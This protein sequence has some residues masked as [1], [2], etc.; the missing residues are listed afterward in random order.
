MLKYKKIRSGDLM[1]I[2]INNQKVEVIITKKKG[3]KN[4]YLRVKE[5][6]KLYVTTS[7]LM[8]D[9]K[10]KNIIEENMESII[11]MYE[12]QSYKQ[13]LKKDFYYLG[14]K[15]DLIKTNGT[16]VVIGEEKIFIPMNFDQDKWLKK[17][18]VQLFK[19]RLDYWYD[20]FD[21]KIP[22]PSLT[23]RKMTSRWGVCNSKL[24]RVTLNLELI[25]KDISCLDYVIVH[26]LSHFVEMN[27]SDR[28][29][30]VVG[31]NYPNYKEI[32]RIMKNY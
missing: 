21:R 20:R 24:K 31:L 14:K 27:H 10:I 32:R 22:Y 29:W 9:R 26:E 17:E 16:N 4:T 15:Y 3:N 18:A 11:R 23:I 28:F 12:K 2:E 8:S 6:L 7:Y 1:L 5:D 13:E 25:K 30:K 19:Q